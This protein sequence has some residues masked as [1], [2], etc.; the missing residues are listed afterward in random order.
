MKYYGT[1]NNKDYGFYLEKFENSIEITDEYWL[2]LLNEQ[3]KGKTII[4]YDNKV[5]CVDITEFENV[6]G[7]WKKLSEEETRIKQL[8]IQNAI[9]EKEIQEELEQLD[10]KRIRAMAEPS[11]K[12]DGT[13][14]LEYYN[15]RIALL[16]SE[17]S[18]I[19]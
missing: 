16:R 8:N 5:V 14:W 6:N 17:L 2:E 3:E 18:Q 11:L 12:D 1:K 7:T 10:K 9:R 13:T 19:S 4:Q 15:N